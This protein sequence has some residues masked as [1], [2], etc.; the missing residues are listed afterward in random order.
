MHIMFVIIWSFY[1]RNS[2]LFKSIIYIIRYIFFLNTLISENQMKYMYDSNR[3]LY[4]NFV[5]WKI[6][7]ILIVNAKYVQNQGLIYTVLFLEQL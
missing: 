1:D 5:T 2:F 3:F 4:N 6:R 7:I